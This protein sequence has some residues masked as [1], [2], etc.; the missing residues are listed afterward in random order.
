MQICI[1]L[2]VIFFNQLTSF[3]SILSGYAQKITDCRY[4]VR[5][6]T[7][8]G[9]CNSILASLYTSRCRL[10]WSGPTVSMP[11]IS[12]PLHWLC[13]I[14]VYFASRSFIIVSKTFQRFLAFLSNIFP[15]VNTF[16][17]F[18]RALRPY[19]GIFE[20]FFSHGLLETFPELS[21]SCIQQMSQHIL[22]DIII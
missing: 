15:H 20:H 17:T 21:H 18:S 19:H 10:A 13:V 8:H 22:V 9:N 4:I 3:F 12:M 6:C 14:S 1:Y 2:L 11:N 16:I 5:P 7:K